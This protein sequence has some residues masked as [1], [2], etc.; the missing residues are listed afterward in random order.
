MRFW[1]LGLIAFIVPVTHLDAAETWSERLGYKADDRVVILYADH[2]GAAFET[3]Q[4]GAKL[5]EQG[6]VSSASVM[7]PCP[8]FADFADWCRDHRGHDI[9]ISLTL[10]SPSRA[11]RWRPLSGPEASPSLIDRD[12]YFWATPNQAAIRVER[13]QAAHELTLQIERARAAGIEPTHLIPG[14]GTLFAR[15]DLMDLYL[16]LAEKY[17]IPAVVVELTPDHI[18]RFKAEGFDFTEEMQHLMQRY[19][20]PKLDDVQFIPDTDNYAAKRKALQDIVQDLEPGLTQIIFSPATE[21]KALKAITPRW[22][23]LVWDAQLLADPQ[24]KQILSKAGV[25]VSNWREVM[26]RFERANARPTR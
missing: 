1:L 21:S 4:I 11:Y 23:Q 12:G 17:W 18:E 2:M 26:E 19:P 10:N 3:N 20:L 14:M 6:R 8:W 15:P 16:N 9:G 24:T 13:D 22:Q 5:L 7:V 25:K